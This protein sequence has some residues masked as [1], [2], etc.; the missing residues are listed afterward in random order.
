[1]A[2][3]GASMATAIETLAHPI[4]EVSKARALVAVLVPVAVPIV[5]AFALS[6]SGHDLWGYGSLIRSGRLSLIRQGLGVVGFIAFVAV[7]VPPALRALTTRNYLASTPTE[8]LTPSG[9]RFNLGEV[10]GISVR[11]TFWHK[12]LFIDLPGQTRRVVVTFARPLA[13]EIADAMK[14]DTNLRNIPIS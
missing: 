11:K 2:Y 12:V 5:L 8:L 13:P 6:T 9:E 3:L 10:K 14:A 7:Y 1:M 4:V